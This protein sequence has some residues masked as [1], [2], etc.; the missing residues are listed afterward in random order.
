MVDERIAFQPETITAEEVVSERNAERRRVLLE[1]MGWERFLSSAQHETI[2]E[3]TDPGGKRVLV[4]IA[5]LNGLDEYRLLRVV[6][7]STG[8]K[9]F[10]RVPPWMMKCHQAAAWIAGFDDPYDY[11]PF[12]ET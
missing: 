2:D 8:R 7:P 11:H 4:R 6:C 1:R 3:D 5:F 12:I 10:I 9:Y